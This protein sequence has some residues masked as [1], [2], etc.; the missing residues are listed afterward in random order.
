MCIREKDV[1]RL[2][3]CIHVYSPGAKADN[4][5]EKILIVTKRVYYFEHTLYITASGL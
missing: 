1:E 3:D 5:E 2:R 4:P